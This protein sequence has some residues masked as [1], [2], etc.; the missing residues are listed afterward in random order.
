MSWSDKMHASWQLFSRSLQV[1]RQNPRLLLFP[2]VAT[3]CT[4]ALM[5]FFLVPIVIYGMTVAA[6]GGNWGHD[7]AH[8]LNGVFYGYG[9]AVYVVSMFLA[10]FFNVAF[11]NEIIRAL[12]GQPVSVSGGFR[13]AVSR[14]GAIA[15][16]S[17]LAAT[18]GLIIRAIEDRL[19]WVGKLVMGLVGVVWSV[20]AVFAI[21]V[22]IRRQDSNPLAVL[23]DSAATLKQT[24]GESLVGFIGIRV[25]GALLVAG[26][27]LIAVVAALFALALHWTVVAILIGA[28][29]LLAM[30]VFGFFVQMATHVYR[31]A[32]YVYASEGVVP[33]PYTADMMNSGWKVKKA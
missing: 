2:A 24:W 26:T 27:V 33:G 4:L 13:F 3:V 12:S 29:W 28:T 22:I 20:A 23:R 25:G 14:I 11:Y 31:C 19:G 30:I 5:A 7:I 6:H 15:L 16:W 21:P 10:T 1:L 18:V 32:L 17:L 8:R 9:V